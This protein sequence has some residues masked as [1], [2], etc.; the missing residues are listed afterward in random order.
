MSTLT[1]TTYTPRPNETASDSS[2]K[3]FDRRTGA[4]FPVNSQTKCPF[5]LP[6]AEDYGPA[7]IKDISPEGLGLLSAT[8]IEEGTLLVI[9]L[10]LQSDK[11]CRPQIVQVV[12]CTRIVGGTFLVGCS[13]LVP[14]T[15]EEMRAYVL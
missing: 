12:H 15:Y 11:A 10:E 14:L 13:F 7:R 5:V 1:N 8:P 3:E 6:V 9:G 4:R 2:V